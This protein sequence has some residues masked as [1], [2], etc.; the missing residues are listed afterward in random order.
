MVL[1]A[2]CEMSILINNNM[3]LSFLVDNLEYLLSKVFYLTQRFLHRHRIHRFQNIHYINDD[4]FY[5]KLQQTSKL[6]LRRRE[7][8]F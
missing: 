2:I 7:T 4:S 6:D 3:S 8:F 5:F 1:T